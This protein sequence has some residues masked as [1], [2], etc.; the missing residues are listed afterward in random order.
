[1]GPCVSNVGWVGL[2]EEK[3]THVHISETKV[4][5]P[6]DFNFDRRLTNP[7]SSTAIV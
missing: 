4:R 7:L 2:G 5:T 6:E 3:W 1:L